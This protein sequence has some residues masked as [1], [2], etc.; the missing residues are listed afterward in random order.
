MAGLT[1][2]GKNKIKRA[3]KLLVLARRLRKQASK[4]KKKGK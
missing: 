1:K 2:A 3:A 4:M